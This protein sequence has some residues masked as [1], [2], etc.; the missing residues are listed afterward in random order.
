VAIKGPLFAG[1]PLLDQSG[2]V[3]GVLVKACKGAVAASPATADGFAWGSA[4]QAATKPAPCTP[5]VVAAPVTAIRSFLMNPPS[6]AAAAPASVPAAAAAP[7]L[8]IRGEPQVA[9]SVHGV[10]VLAVAPQ[11]PAEASGLKPSAD[12]IAA[13]DGEAVDT[14]QKLSAAIGKHA[15]GDTVKL[16]VF[17]GGKFREVQV[18]L[19]A[20]P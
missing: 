2:D 8:G 20:A 11:S 6:A 5:T 12:V 7:W 13:V 14:P 19:R 1:A 4:P 18:V 9:G 3:V 15:A 17:G 10:Q 16:L